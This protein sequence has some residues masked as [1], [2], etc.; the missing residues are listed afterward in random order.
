MPVSIRCIQP[1]RGQEFFA[2]VMQ[3]QVRNWSIRFRPIRPHSP[4]L[5]GK[6]ER[7]Q[8]TALE[9]FWPTVDLK[10]PEINHGSTSTTSSAR[11]TASAAARPSIGSAT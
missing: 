3:D 5:N 10:D 4:H 8:K 2:Y 11:M 1:D 9:E 6:V 7:V